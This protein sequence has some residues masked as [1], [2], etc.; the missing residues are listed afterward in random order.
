MNRVYLHSCSFQ[1]ASGTKKMAAQFLNQQNEL[2]Y[3]K[4]FDG[5]FTPIKEIHRQLDFH[6]DHIL[7]QQGWQ[8]QELPQIPILLGSTGYTVTDLEYRLSQNQTLDFDYNLAALGRHLQ[9]RYCSPVFH[10]A[11]SCT[12][13]AQAVYAAYQMIHSGGCSKAIVVGLEHFN[14]F[15]F[16]HFYAMNLLAQ[17]ETYRPFVQPQGMILGEGIA[18]L[19][20]SSAAETAFGCEI[21]AAAS[22]TDHHNLTNSNAAVLEQLL[23]RITGQA[24]ITPEDITAVKTHGIGGAFDDDEQTLLRQTL[25]NSKWLLAKPFLGHTLG[26]SGALETAWLLENLR[27]GHFPPLPYQNQAQHLPL[28]HGTP[29]S[30]GLYL[31]YFLGFGGSNVGWL[32]HWQH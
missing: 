27:S 32:L 1:T 17:E 2:P 19:A 24:G 11:T 15:T 25:P 10:F 30:D 5:I 13:S 23:K 21:L 4:A 16:E 20:L 29:V 3:F 8:R 26:A 22:V 12:S 31:N 14:R 9:Q 6:I 18:C 28:A 7:Q